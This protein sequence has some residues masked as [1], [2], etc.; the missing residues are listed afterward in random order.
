MA[1]MAGALLDGDMGTNVSTKVSKDLF[2]KRIHQ[3]ICGLNKRRIAAL[4]MVCGL[5]KRR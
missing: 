4:L 2:S 3:M 5:I 1:W